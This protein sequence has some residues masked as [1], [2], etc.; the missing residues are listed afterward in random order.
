V[1][2]TYTQKDIRQ[3]HQRMNNNPH[4]RKV[5]QVTA[6]HQRNRQN[7]MRKHLPVVRPALFAV[8]DVDLVEPPAELPEIV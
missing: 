2:T 1:I 5:A 6:D 7:V 3:I 8:D 4:P